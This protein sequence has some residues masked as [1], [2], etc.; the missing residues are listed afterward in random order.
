MGPPADG[1]ENLTA[2]FQGGEWFRSA[3]TLKCSTVHP[4]Q[5]H[6]PHSTHTHC[7]GDPRQSQHLQSSQIPP[8]KE[9]LES[10]CFL[11]FFMGG[12][13]LLSHLFSVCFGVGSSLPSGQPALPL[14]GSHPPSR[15]VG[16][17]YLPKTAPGDPGR[18]QGLGPA[19]GQSLQGSYR[20]FEDTLVCFV[21]RWATE[22]M[23]KM[24]MS[25]CHL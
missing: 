13:Y 4:P 6:H 11:E 16:H 14:P 17:F 8:R 23:E 12:F 24:S 2:S 22:R 20:G 18:P 9:D 19:R 1:K 5:P 25:Y 7:S 15:A 21:C 3:S 10:L